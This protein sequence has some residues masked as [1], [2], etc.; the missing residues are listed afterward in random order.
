MPKKTVVDVPLLPHEIPTPVPMPIDPK[1]LR[2]NDKPGRPKGVKDS[3]P[4]KRRKKDSIEK[5]ERRRKEYEAKYDAAVKEAEAAGLPAPPKPKSLQRN[6]WSKYEGKRRFPHR[7]SMELVQALE[8]YHIQPLGILED[9][10]KDAEVSNSEKAKVAL[11]LLNF[12][13]PTKKA[14]EV[15]GNGGGPLVIA[16]QDQTMASIWDEPALDAEVITDGDTNATD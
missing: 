6:R 2:V 16:F 12:I 1:R 10:F 7:E 8:R 13:Y 5:A 14:V 3:Q 11:R 15:S 9:F 4:R